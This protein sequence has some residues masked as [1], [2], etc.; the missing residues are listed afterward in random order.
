MPIKKMVNNLKKLNDDE[1]IK[2]KLDMKKYIEEIKIMGWKKFWK[3]NNKV[4]YFA[5]TILGALILINIF[6]NSKII[7]TFRT[8]DKWS[9]IYFVATFLL[10]G[11]TTIFIINFM[12]T[13]GIKQEFNT[14]NFLR[15]KEKLKGVDWKSAEEPYLKKKQH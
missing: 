5:G 12:A 2:S 4:F 13:I 7:T 6:L 1:T 3:M 10:F 9:M 15:T 14:D 11:G 8:D